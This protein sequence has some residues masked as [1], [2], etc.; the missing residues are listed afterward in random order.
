MYNGNISAISWTHPGSPANYTTELAKV[1]L[2]YFKELVNLVSLEK[3]CAE[4]EK[5]ISA[6][7]PESTP[8]DN[9]EVVEEI[10]PVKGPEAKQLPKPTP[11]LV[12]TVKRSYEPK[13]NNEQYVLLAECVE[14]IRL[15]R[16]PAT[17]GQLK[18][19]FNGKLFEPLQVMNQLSLVCLLDKLKDNGYI[20]KAWLTTAFGN[21]DFVSFRKPGVER[22]YGTGQHYLTMDQLKSRRSDSKIS[23]IHGE[24][25]MDDM[26]E[27]MQECGDK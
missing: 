21:R 19:L 25:N 26:I 13:L 11:E 1:S 12:A 27:K 8:V 5:Y 17:V 15:F 20:K 24:D 2:P 14:S 3:L 6:A 18:K 4:V 16:R 22:R 23:Y 7:K 9:A 10:V